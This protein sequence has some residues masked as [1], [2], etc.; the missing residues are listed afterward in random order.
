M[1]DQS[2]SHARAPGKCQAPSMLRMS[3]IG[4]CATRRDPIEG[5]LGHGWFEALSCCHLGAALETGWSGVLGK[6]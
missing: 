4:T 5:C 3:M 2:S 1:I 6:R